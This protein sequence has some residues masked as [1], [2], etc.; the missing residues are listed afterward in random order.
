MI[1]HMGIADFTNL[2]Q[3]LFSV[4]YC[5]VYSPHIK[6][7]KYLPIFFFKLKKG[8]RRN[9]NMNVCRKNKQGGQHVPILA[10]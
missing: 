2:V 7:K 9:I 8:N 5:K 10:N 3:F 1:C 4:L 6:V